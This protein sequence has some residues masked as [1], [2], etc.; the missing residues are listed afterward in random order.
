MDAAEIE[1]RR[2]SSIKAMAERDRAEWD[3]K[4]Q[5]NC[6]ALYWRIGRCCAGCDHWR[7]DAGFVGECSAA[8]IMSGAD[9]LRSMNVTYSS[10]MPKPGFPFTKSEHTCGLFSDDF[11][12]SSLGKD[13][14]ERIGAMKS[15][16]LRKKPPA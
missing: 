11:D 9:V 15:G 6:D 16:Q 8:G 4:Y 7:S 13:Y 3:Q 14:L 2:Q 12:W 10:Y 1:R 5:Q